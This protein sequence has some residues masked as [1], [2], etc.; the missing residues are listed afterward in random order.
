MRK[1]ILATLLGA[2]LVSPL[3]LAA[4]QAST[5]HAA[6]AAPRAAV[7]TTQ[8]TA[9]GSCF[10]LAPNFS[11]R[12]FCLFGGVPDC[13]GGVTPTRIF[14]IDGLIEY[15]RCGTISKPPTPGGCLN[16]A[17]TQNF[18]CLGRAK[19]QGTCTNGFSLLIIHRYHCTDVPT[20]R[21][22]L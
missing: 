18:T 11:N 14:G 2:V 10:Q 5:T 1:A 15:Y 12:Y 21:L 9:Q 3:G 22:G 4:A 7:H 16:P 6:P 19:P 13:P 8:A 20:R 17:G